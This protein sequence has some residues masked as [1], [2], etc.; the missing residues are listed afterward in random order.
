MA[1]WTPP[2]PNPT[3]TYAE[4]GV[5]DATLKVTDSTGRS[6]AASVVIIVGNQAPVVELTTSPA[7][8]DPF[9]FGQTVT[10]RSR[11]PTTRRSTAPRS[12]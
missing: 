3:F 7:P 11:S 8:G 4:N 5:Y 9:Q 6:A 12:P 10:S 2:S 1:R